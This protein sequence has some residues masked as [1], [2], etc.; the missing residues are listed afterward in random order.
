MQSELEK[1]T[2]MLQENGVD[3]EYTTLLT[4][5]NDRSKKNYVVYTDEI[6]DE[7][8]NFNIFASSYNPESSVFRLDPIKDEKEWDTIN[9]V[10]NNLINVVE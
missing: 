4:F 8:D 5:Y 10:L 6:R 9:E 3:K 1:G 7:D 2:F